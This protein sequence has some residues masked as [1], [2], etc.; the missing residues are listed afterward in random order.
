MLCVATC[1]FGQSDRGTITGTV[2]DPTGALIPAAQVVLTNAETGYRAETVTTATGN[3]TLPALPVGVYKLS[4][5]HAGFSKADRT[6]ISVQ[7]AVTTRVDVELQVG[8]ATQAVEVSAESTLLKTESGEQSTTITGAQLNSLP[9][10]FG[11]GAGAIRNPLSFTQMTP[12]ATINGWNNI[13]VNGTNGGFRILFEGQESSSS[14]DPRVSDESQPSVEA[15]QEFSLQTSNFAPE[16][17]I[18]TGGLY[19]FTSRSGTNQFHGSGYIYLQNTA[20]NSGLP[21][22]DN[23]RGRHVE[24]VKHLAD[25]GFSVGGPVWLPKVYNGKNRTFF[26]FNW[27]RYRDRESLYNGITTVPNSTLRNGDFSVILGR[28]LGTDFAGRAILQ[29]AIYDPSTATI[30]S[31]GRRV[32]NVFPNNAIPTNRFD[33]VAV[34]ILSM[35]PKPNIADTLVNNFSAG[36]A[37]WKLQQIPSIKIDH[38]FSEKAKISGYFSLENTNKS[39][40]VDGLPEPISQVRLQDIHSKTFRV[41]Y[42]TSLTPTLLLHLGAGV[43]RYY[44]P[45]TVPPESGDYDNKQLGNLN[46]PGTGFPRFGGG[47]LGGNTYGGMTLAVGPGNRGLYLDVKPTGVAQ[48]TWVHGNHTYKTGGE[49]KIDTFTNISYIGLS[50]AYGFSSSQ[51]SQP[52]YGQTLPSGTGIGYNFASFLLGAYD[53][54]SIG[55]T[56]NPQYRRSAWGFFVQDTWKINRKLTLDYGLRYDLQ[57]PMREL[58][59]RTSTFNRNIPNPNA[60][61]RL[62]GVLYQGPGPGRCDCHLVSTYPYAIAPRIGIAYQI[63]P[64]TVLRAGWG[65]SFASV[66]AFNYIGGG[67]SQGMG[68]NTINFTSPGNGVAA[69]QISQPLAWDQS[70]LYGASYNPG[71]LVTPGAAV[72]NAPATVDPNGGRPPRINQWNVSLQRE[73]TKDLVLEASYLGNRGAWLQ[74]GGNLISYN[75][76][77]PSVYQKLGLDITNAT[78]RTLLTS[79]ITSPLAVAAGFTKPYANFPDTGTV[80]QS[81]RPFPQYNGIGSLWAPLGAS[82]YNALQT[83]LTKRSSHGLTMTAAYAFSK[84]LDSFSGAGDIFNRSTFKSLSPNDRPHLLSFSIDYT[85]PAYG[86]IRKNRVARTLLAGWTIGSISQYASGPLL[87]APGS[88]NSLGT[89]LPGQGTRQFRVPG[90]SLYLKDLNCGCIDPTQETVLNPAAWVDQP[91]GVYG[92]GSAYYSDFRGQRRPVESMSL[93][94]RF[95]IRER[96]SFSIRA[97]FFNP[98]NRMEVVSDPSTGSPSNPPTRSNGVLTGGFGYM[99]YTA[100]SSNAVGGTLPAPRT[101]QIVARFEF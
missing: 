70:A 56:V 64:Q 97:E 1:A 7:V 51:T 66:S 35:F 36:G 67:N 87:G 86:F 13:T 76:I 44:N 85:V 15:I 22:T 71:L 91:A 11:I 12:G 81:L 45:D 82:W 38:N 30:D 18:V 69:G 34:K 63:A 89:Y 5:S 28:N 84:T 72:Q 33:P 96:M 94:K 10:N 23:G 21:F 9:I 4:V 25:G 62:G 39:N 31:S 26:F 75:A 17:G 3:Y 42:D 49:W 74:S 58:W 14:L 52:L 99:N 24:I 78:T 40:G 93:G 59:N 92:T 65:L 20:F 6:N 80:I 47:S 48:L 41:N 27:E 61:G 19:N 8:S 54:A 101:G 100:I 37:F 95:P 32:L 79:S 43:Q 16:F 68:F 50:P 53:S 98:F 60:N 90:V 55:D 73:V 29:N 2:A 46:A 88:N 83:K 57:T 77:N